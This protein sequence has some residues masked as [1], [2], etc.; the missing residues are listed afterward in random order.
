MSS[1]DE[2]GDGAIRKLENEY[3]LEVI[4]RE[5]GYLERTEGMIRK[6]RAALLERAR[7]IGLTTFTW[8]V[9]LKKTK[10][11]SGNGKVE[12]SV[13]SMQVPEVPEGRRHAVYPVGEG[14]RWEG[15]EHR[16]EAVALAAE[17]AK[18]YGCQITLE[19]ITLTRN[20]Q[21]TH[22]RIQWGEVITV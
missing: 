15:Q 18:K 1:Y 14:K 16:A 6:Y 12:Y 7:V 11:Y 10:G 17:L 5:F 21:H 19:G 3:S 4:K 2:F 8:M 22:Y 13:T 20:E 9:I